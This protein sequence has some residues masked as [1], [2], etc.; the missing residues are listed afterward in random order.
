MIRFL[1]PPEHFSSMMTR[2]R[3]EAAPYRAPARIETATLEVLLTGTGRV[4]GLKSAEALEQQRGLF[5][6]AEEAPDR[7]G[8]DI[9][10]AGDTEL[11]KRPCV[12][13]VGTRAVSPEGIARAR[14]IATDLA[15]AGIVVV[16]GLAK[17]VDAV[18]LNAAIEAGGRVIGVIGTPLDRATPTENGPLQEQMCRE[19]L[20]VSQ[21]AIGSPTQKSHFPQ[22]NRTMATVSDGTVVVEASDTSGTLHQ[23]AECTRLGR[24]L[25]ILKSV[26]EAPGV[27]WPANFLRYDRTVVVSRSADVISRIIASEK[28]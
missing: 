25:F 13:V 15:K 14:R 5:A 9:Y 28:R 8:L 4:P 21:F 27:T 18:A 1:L 24:W 26:T 19:H 12:A 11:L 10:Y 20:V 6:P 2:R 23:A 22:R 7:S 3:P 16:S 17:G